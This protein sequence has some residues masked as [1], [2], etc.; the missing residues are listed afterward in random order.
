[1]KGNKGKEG[2]AV[3]VKVE[4]LNALRLSLEEERRRCDRRSYFKRR[5]EKKETF[6]FLSNVIK[7]VV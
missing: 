1:L 3:N 7:G 2:K 5:G 6:F 4:A